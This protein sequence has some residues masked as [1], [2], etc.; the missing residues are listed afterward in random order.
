MLSE[1]F[2]EGRIACGLGTEQLVLLMLFGFI[3]HGVCTTTLL[4]PVTGALV[5]SRPMM[6]YESPLVVDGLVLDGPGWSSR[7]DQVVPPSRLSCTSQWSGSTPDQV[8]LMIGSPAAV[9]TGASVLTVRPCPPPR[10]WYVA[11]LPTLSHDLACHQGTGLEAAQVSGDRQK[12]SVADHGHAK[13]C[14]VRR[15]DD[16]RRSSRRGADR[17]Q[18]IIRV[19]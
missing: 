16:S 10:L 17:D 14:S 8:Q 18:K 15:Q 2:V 3:A 9:R 5:A 7:C 11:H 13:L 12:D 6:R 19:E 1:R 4:M